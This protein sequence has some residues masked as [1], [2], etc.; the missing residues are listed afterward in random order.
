[1]TSSIKPAPSAAESS[2]PEWDRVITAKSGWLDL[3]NYR[4]A[5]T[6]PIPFNP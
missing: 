4:F 6:W 1:M 2:P 5:R 3:N